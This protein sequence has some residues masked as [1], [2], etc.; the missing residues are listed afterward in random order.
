MADKT[1]KS[2]MRIPTDKEPSNFAVV[3]K[4]Y[5]ISHKQLFCEF[6]SILNA[7]L[8]IPKISSFIRGYK[9]NITNP[10]LFLS[11]KRYFIKSCSHIFFVT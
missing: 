8:N 6:C 3:S 1:I 9:F 4:T 11:P 10:G 2:P 5:R 7:N